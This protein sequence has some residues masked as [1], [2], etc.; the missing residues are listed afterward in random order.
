M[1]KDLNYIAK[2]EKAI[3]EKYGDKAAINPRSLWTEEKEK[4]FIETLKQSIK[5]EDK[6]L[7]TKERVEH[8]GIFIN[9]KI[10]KSSN[11]KN[12][13]CCKNYSLDKKDDIYLLKFNTCYG[14]Y[15]KY[16][17]DRESRW[18]SGWRPQMEK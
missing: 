2:L 11:N 15:I 6:N 1:Q 14:C 7:Q 3:S 9:K 13:E 12:C 10:L 18:L 16:I 4:V 8:E 5:K 17:E